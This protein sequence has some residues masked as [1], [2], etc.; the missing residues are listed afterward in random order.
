MIRAAVPS[1]PYAN[2]VLGVFY[3]SRQREKEAAKYL[4]VAATN[5]DSDA[6]FALADLYIR[7]NRDTD[8]LSILVGAPA[9]DDASGAVSL[10][11]AR[12][13]FR[14]NR[15][16]DAMRRI[17]ALLTR[18]PHNPRAVL[19]KAQFLFATGDVEQALRFARAAVSE[20][21]MSS[22]ARSTLG[23]TLSATGDAENAFNEYVE[24]LRL[25]PAAPGPPMELARLALVLGRQNEALEYA[26]QAVRKNPQNMDAA[27]TLVKTLVG[28]HNYSAADRELKP[29]LSRYPTSPAVLLQLANL[30]GARGEGAAARTT[31]LRALGSDRDSREALTGLVSLDLKEGKIAEARQRIDRVIAAHSKDAGYLLLAAQVYSAAHDTSRTESMLRSVLEMD[32]ANVTAVLSLASLLDG[33][34]RRDEA[35]RLLEEFVERQPRSVDAQTSLG[36]ILEETGDAGA[37]QTRYEK[38][39]AQDPHAAM[40]SYRLAA[41][42]AQHESSL[43]AALSLVIVAE[44]QLSDN[45]AVSDLL[46]WLYTRRNLPTLGLPHLQDAVRAVPDNAIYRYHLGY[47]QMN[48]G[49]LREAREQFTQAL[50]IDKNFAEADQV[51]KLLKGL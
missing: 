45:P 9:A 43:E 34:R 15:R 35:R 29:L 38:I 13:E 7:T 32:R 16:E 11:M 4:M 24:A 51:R 42:Y 6:R 44:Q 47:A 21:P 28:V 39:I 17:D 30:Q 41:L 19:L 22:E 3:L 46:G 8:A 31:F 26:R 12:V 33:Q 10:R 5:G 23:Q 50:A 37:A 48:V 18:L 1:N 2:R 49:H 36:M 27:V 20:D 14:S 40:A 25:S